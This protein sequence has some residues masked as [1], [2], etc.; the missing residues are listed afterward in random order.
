MSF[1][2]KIKGFRVKIWEILHDYG[3]TTRSK[4]CKMLLD[5]SHMKI[6]TKH[7]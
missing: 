1:K 3:H 7:L 6:D 5:Y 4:I 2:T